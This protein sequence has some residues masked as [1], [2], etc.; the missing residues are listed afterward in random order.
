[1]SWP[2]YCP[3]IS[4][5]TIYIIYVTSTTIKQS[6]SIIVCTDVHNIVSPAE[7]V[8]V[9]KLL[10]LTVNPVLFLIF[11]HQF[12]QYYSDLRLYVVYEFKFALYVFPVH[13]KASAKRKIIVR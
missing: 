2:V 1:M 4:D 12:E 10:S 13:L 11:M 6:Q 3:T 7:H 5:M 8:F 9:T